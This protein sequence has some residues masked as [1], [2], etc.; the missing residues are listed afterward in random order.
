MREHIVM[1]HVDQI[2]LGMDTLKRSSSSRE[3]WGEDDRLVS[4]DLIARSHFTIRARETRE[5][6]V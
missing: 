5:A 4:V 6:V 1:V 3:M 2:Y